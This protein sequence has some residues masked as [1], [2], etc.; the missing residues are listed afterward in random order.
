MFPVEY[1]KSITSPQ[2]ELKVGQK[3]VIQ[4][5]NNQKIGTIEKIARVYM[6]VSYMDGP[7][8]KE[9]EF[10][11]DNWCNRFDAREMII[12]P[13]RAEFTHQLNRAHAIIQH[14]HVELPS[15]AQRGDHQFIF[16][17]ADSL[18]DFYGPVEEK[19]LE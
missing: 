4:R 6:T 1:Y 7:R 2:P 8:K 13:E 10:R 3:V 5:F 9:E 17:L 18:V 12:H 14:F 19:A 15:V 11:K 16:F